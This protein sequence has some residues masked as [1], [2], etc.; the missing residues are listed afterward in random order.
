MGNTN[1]CCPDDVQKPN[2]AKDILGELRK[3]TFENLPMDVENEVITKDIAT[4]KQ[5]PSKNS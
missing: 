2:V 5:R 4:T 1:V 3:K